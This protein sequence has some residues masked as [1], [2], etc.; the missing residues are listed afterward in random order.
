MYQ[1]IFTVIHGNGRD[2]P[3]TV[4]FRLI[5]YNFLYISTKCAIKYDEICGN[6]FNPIKNISNHIDIIIEQY[7]KRNL[8]VAIPLAYFCLKQPG[9]F[10]GYPETVKGFFKMCRNNDNFNKYANQVN[11]IIKNKSLL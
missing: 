3:H 2:V 4:D 1:D 10:S 9:Y 7:S 8:N 5:D 6:G 11:Y